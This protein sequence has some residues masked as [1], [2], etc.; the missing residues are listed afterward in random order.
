MELLEK[1]FDTAF[2]AANGI[3]NLRGLILGLA[4]KGKLVAQKQDSLPISEFLREIAVEREELAK[5]KKIKLPNLP[6]KIKSEEIPYEIPQQWQWVR[7]GEVI[8]LRSCT[9]LDKPG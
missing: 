7:L 3:E 1:H 8:L 9:N 6:S 2:S 5:K 4:L